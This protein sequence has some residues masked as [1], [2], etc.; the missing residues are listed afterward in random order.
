MPK[1]SRTTKKRKALVNSLA[2]SL[3]LNGRIMT[4]KV[5]AKAA[6]QLV[7]KLITKGKVNNLNTIRELTP[8]VGRDSVRKLVS[9]ISPSFTDR[10]GGYTRVLNLPPRKSDSAPMALVEII[11]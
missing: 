3:I 9:E 8:V 7:D 2:R 5:Q 1:F 6:G 4:T 11:K 10:K